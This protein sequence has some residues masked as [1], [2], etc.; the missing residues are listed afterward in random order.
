MT[1]QLGIPSDLLELDKAP[2]WDFIDGP[3]WH[4]RSIGNANAILDVARR[5]NLTVRGLLDHDAA[6]QH[7]LVGT[8]EQVARSIEQWFT[9]RAADGFN[10]NFDIFPSGL[11]QIVDYWSGITAT[12]DFPPRV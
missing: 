7:A 2:P 12:G 11:E 4:P 1:A 9:Q 6:S 3:Q 8:P 5:E 10:I